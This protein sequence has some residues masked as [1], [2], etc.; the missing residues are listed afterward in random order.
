MIALA[1]GSQVRLVAILTKKPEPGH[2]SEGGPKGTSEES[3]CL[4]KQA[5]AL[6]V[7]RCSVLPSALGV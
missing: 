4:K 6:I 5:L 1:P 7:T 2:G 3:W